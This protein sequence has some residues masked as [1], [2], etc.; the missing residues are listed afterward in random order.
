MDVLRRL[1]GRP[2]A[3][4]LPVDSTVP[5]NPRSLTAVPYAGN[6]D[7]E[8][9]GESFRQ[10]ELWQ[11]V[12]GRTLD[13]VRHSIQAVLFA[14]TDNPHDANAISVW[15]RNMRV[16]YLARDDA[17]VYRPGLLALEQKEMS[18]IALAGVIVGGGVRADGLGLLGVWLSHDPRDF[19]VPI[20]VPPD[21][22]VQGAMR[23]GLSAALTTDEEDDSYDL[24]WLTQ[25]QSDHVAA[26]KQLQALLESDPDPIDRHFMFCE[27]ERRLY[28]ARDVYASALDRYDE[29][30]RQHDTEMDAILT[31][32]FA[33]FN[34]VPLLETYTQMAI[35]QQ[36]ARNWAAALW[37]AERGAALYGPHAARPEALEDL[38]KR[39]VAYREKLQERDK[40]SSKRTPG[41]TILRGEQP[42]EK[43]PQLRELRQSLRKTR[44][45]RS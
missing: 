10:D 36:K 44:G 19:G 2:Q 20:V 42:A 13:R 16:G 6:H 32:L 31:A 45:P 23:T 24:S 3:P 27:L 22:V 34:K 12:G 30:C 15:I 25:L 21:P 7:L 5:S 28:R 8:V 37:W 4:A 41:A 43:T 35:R 26:I 40:V 18:H 38:R 9:V 39:I 29:T 11:I 33:K 1:L 17:A 14:E